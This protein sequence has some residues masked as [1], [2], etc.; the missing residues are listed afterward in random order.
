MRKR[1]G[2]ELGRSWPR[3]TAGPKAKEIRIQGTKTKI[4]AQKPCKQNSSIP[5]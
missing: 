1:G 5:I 2:K 3:L 4:K